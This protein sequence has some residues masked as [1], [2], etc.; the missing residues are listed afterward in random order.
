MGRS[1]TVTVAVHIEK[2]F[3]LKVQ[4]GLYC[5]F[6]ISHKAIDIVDRRCHD[7]GIL[8]N[9]DLLVADN[10]LDGLAVVCLP[11]YAH[12]V[13]G[14][15]GLVDAADSERRGHILIVRADDRNADS[16][17]VVNRKCKVPEQ[18]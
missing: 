11:D 12:T 7:R 6:I 5:Q 16:K 8:S 18:L 13:D 9:I 3:R 2:W 1:A 14:Y 10:D 15:G 4:S 17:D